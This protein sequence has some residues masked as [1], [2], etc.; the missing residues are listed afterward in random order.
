MRTWLP[1]ETS[2][3]P[4]SN[5]PTGAPVATQSANPNDL[6]SMFQPKSNQYNLTENLRPDV[7]SCPEGQFPEY[8][9]GPC[10]GSV[11]HGAAGLNDQAMSFGPT[12]G[13]VT[14]G[15]YSSAGAP[16]AYSIGSFRVENI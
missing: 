9:G 15:G 11:A 1:M 6:T 10:R 13:V 16:A 2:G 8:P 3:I 12:Q 5:I 7:A 14:P 4:V